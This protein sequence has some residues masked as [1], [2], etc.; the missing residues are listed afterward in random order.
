MLYPDHTEVC[1]PTVGDLSTRYVE[2]LKK[3][4]RPLF[5]FVHAGLREKSGYSENM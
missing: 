5:L 1:F 4:V 2:M 3:V